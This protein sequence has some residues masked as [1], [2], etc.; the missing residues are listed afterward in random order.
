MFC[1][2]SAMIKSAVDVLVQPIE[3]GWLRII[4]NKTELK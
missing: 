2:T 3:A 4:N 1:V